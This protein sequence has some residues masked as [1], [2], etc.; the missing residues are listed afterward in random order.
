MLPGPSEKILD[1][2]MWLKNPHSV[3]VKTDYHSVPSALVFTKSQHELSEMLDTM[4]INCL[5]ATPEKTFNILYDINSIDLK[6]D[7]RHQHSSMDLGHKTNINFMI[8]L[9]AD[10]TFNEMKKQV[11]HSHSVRMCLASISLRKYKKTLVSS[12]LVLLS[13]FGDSIS[14]QSMLALKFSDAQ[15][16]LEFT[17]FLLPQPP[18]F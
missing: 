10:I 16:G 13:A 4:L 6:S 12:F 9:Q 14:L 11:L 5:V 17:L 7:V 8:N 18:K 15:D 2:Y 3:S 1:T